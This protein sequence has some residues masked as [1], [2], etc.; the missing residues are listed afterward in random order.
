MM[1]IDDGGWFIFSGNSAFFFKSSKPLKN[2]DVVV[3][4]FFK[5]RFKHLASFSRH[6]LKFYRELEAHK[7]NLNVSQYVCEL[8][9][10]LIHSSNIPSARVKSET[11]AIYNYVYCPCG[12]CTD[13]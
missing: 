7:L 6:L 5:C 9:P 12:V 8:Y 1:K 2:F 3:S 4:F 10:Q 11:A 13:V